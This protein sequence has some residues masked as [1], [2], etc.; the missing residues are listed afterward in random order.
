MRRRTLELLAPGDCFAVRRFNQEVLRLK[1]YEEGKTSLVRSFPSK[2][3]VIHALTRTCKS[4]IQTDEP[5]IR[6]RF[7]PC[8]VSQGRL[9]GWGA[10]I[11]PAN[12]RRPTD[13]PR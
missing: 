1:S 11:A 9:V 12:R 8:V 3:G 10:R 2:V 6:T 7:Q 5:K 13:P 4:K